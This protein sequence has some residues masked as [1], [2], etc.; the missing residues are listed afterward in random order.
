MTICEGGGDGTYGTDMTFSGLIVYEVSVDKGFSERGRVANP[1][2]A[3][4][5]Y[6]NSLCS[7]WWLNAS[8]EVKRSLF[9]D[10][11]VYAVSANGLHVQDTRAMGHDVATVTF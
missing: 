7:N 2:T 1:P 9:M 6:D 8:S 3:N 4:G 5:Q 10:D 11:F